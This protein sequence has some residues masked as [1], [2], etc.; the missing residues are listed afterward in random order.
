MHRRR[1][2]LDHP[3]DW[4]GF[5]RAARTLVQS[6]VPPEQV[7]WFTPSDAAADLF[8]SASCGDW[9]GD[10]NSNNTQNSGNRNEALQELRALQQLRWPHKKPSNNRRKSCKAQGSPTAPACPQTLCASAKPWCCTVTLRVFR[11]C[12]ACS[13]A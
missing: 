11:S 10:A 8:A 7:D 9:R 2:T 13:G 12:T 4:P 6:G 1:V 3:T 5:R